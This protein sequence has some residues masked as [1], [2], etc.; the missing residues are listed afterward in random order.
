M[1]EFGEIW[2][3]EVFVN[4]DLFDSL[5]CRGDWDVGAH[6]MAHGARLL[7]FVVAEKI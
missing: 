6:A 5:D 1:R 4:Q 2:M 3:T 7:C